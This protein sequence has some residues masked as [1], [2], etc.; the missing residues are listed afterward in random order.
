MHANRILAIAILSALCV[1]PALAATSGDGGQAPASRQERL[2]SADSWLP[3]PTLAAC[4]L[5]RTS[6]SGTI[7]VDMGIDVPDANLRRHAAANG[8]RIRDALRTALSTYANAYYRNRTAPD[9]A[10]ITRLL[11]QAVDQTLGASGGR[12][13]LVN[14]IYQRRQGV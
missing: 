6:T 5:N 2:T 11:Q 1:G 7:I 8:P 3:M 10:T 4:I 12:V 13:L 14:I 9:P